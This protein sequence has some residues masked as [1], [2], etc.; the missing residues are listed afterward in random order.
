[1]TMLLSLVLNYFFYKRSFIP[2]YETRLDPKGLNYYPSISNNQQD[3]TKPVVMFYGDSRALAWPNPELEE[4]TFINRGI[5]NQSSEQVVLRF[6]QHVANI[7]PDIIVIQVCIND[8][9]VISLFPKR[10]EIIVNNCKNNLKQLLKMS[11]DINAKVIMTTVFP[12]AKVSIAHNILGI[13]GAPI[14][15]AV[16][17]V[18]SFIGALSSSNIIVF[19]SYS[20]LKGKERRIKKEYSHDWLHLDTKGY[21]H[22]NKSLSQALLKIRI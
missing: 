19:D 18:N 11:S 13:K 20:L 1:M 15:E 5:G 17:K 12:L 8:L 3:K 9:K 22:L 16:D 14:I 4:F 7:K 21:E 2:L 6:Q 10:R